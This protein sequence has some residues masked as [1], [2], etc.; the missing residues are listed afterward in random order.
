MD[1]GKDRYNGGEQ[2]ETL[3]RERRAVL[4]TGSGKGKRRRQ[5][6]RPTLSSRGALQMDENR[7][8]EP[9]RRRFIKTAAAGATFLISNNKASP[10][11]EAEAATI[12]QRGKLFIADSQTHIFW[13]REGHATTSERG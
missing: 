8:E 5:L 13:R 1:N 12:D 10:R 4:R 6:S 11:T 2:R 3:V 7:K 9:S